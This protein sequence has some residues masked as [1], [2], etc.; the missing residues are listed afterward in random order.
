MNQHLNDSD[1]VIVRDSKPVVIK[2]QLTIEVKLLNTRKK[3]QWKLCVYASGDIQTYSALNPDAIPLD[4]LAGLYEHQKFAKVTIPFCMKIDPR[5]PKKL[6]FWLYCTE[7][8]PQ[9]KLRVQLL[10]CWGTIDTEELVNTSTPALCLLYDSEEHAPAR[11]KVGVSPNESLNRLTFQAE[12]LNQQEWDRFIDRIDTTY[13]KFSYDPYQYFA[14]TNTPAGKLPLICFPLLVTMLKVDSESAEQTMLNLM[15]IAKFHVPPNSKHY[16]S[17]VIG[18][19]CTLITR[20]L[21]YTSDQIRPDNESDDGG[22]DTVTDQWVRLGCFPDLGLAGYDCEDGSECVMEVLHVLKYGN[23]KDSELVKLQN[24]MKKYTPMLAVC[25]LR[26][27]QG[28]VVPHAAVIA[29]DTRWVDTLVTKTELSS[30]DIDLLPVMMIES[31]YYTESVWSSSTLNKEGV[32]RYTKEQSIFEFLSNDDIW[33]L[34]IK[35]KTPAH[36]TYALDMYPSVTA[37]LTADYHDPGTRAQHPLHLLLYESRSSTQLGVNAESISMYHPDLTSTEAITFTA[38]ELQDLKTLAL[39]ELP[40]SKFPSVST[41]STFPELASPAT[42][43]YSF[44]MRR[45]EFDKYREQLEQAI[46]QFSNKVGLRSTI[47]H[48]KLTNN[49][50]ELTC[51]YFFG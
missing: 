51:I 2:L 49:G 5:A 25:K 40:P 44:Q 26:T 12:Q 28:Q 13:N 48:W 37:L 27:G 8:H 18:E 30:N 19:M 39:A 17:K 35:C 29:L 50:A 33:K 11:V 21:V 34:V 20:S 42:L 36:V 41:V 22:E 10:M 32:R 47:K 38:D 4:L 3:D 9:T 1:I 7:E 14:Y 23:F 16:E 31:T 24:V 15:Q 6:H 46:E 45:L 43:E